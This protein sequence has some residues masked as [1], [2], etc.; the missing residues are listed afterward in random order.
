MSATIEAFAH[1]PQPKITQ[2]VFG[3]SVVAAEGV[4]NA[5]GTVGVVAIVAIGAGLVL[6]EVLR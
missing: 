5:L 2:L 3:L 4:A 6:V 1:S